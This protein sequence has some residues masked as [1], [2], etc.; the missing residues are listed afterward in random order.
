MNICKPQ[1]TTQK[2][3][4]NMTWNPYATNMMI[5]A[6]QNSKRT[7]VDVWVKD[8]EIAKPLHDFISVQTKFTKE[9]LMHTNTWANAVGDAVAKMMK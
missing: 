5:D 1:H 4:L 3:I 7:F 9:A 8:Q 2:G 6:I